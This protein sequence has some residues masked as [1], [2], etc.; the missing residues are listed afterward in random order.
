MIK[1]DQGVRAVEL[2]NEVET[3]AR[4]GYVCVSDCAA[5]S[6]GGPSGEVYALEKDGSFG[7]RLEQLSFVDEQAQRDSGSVLDF[8]GL[9]HGAHSADLSPDGKLLYVADM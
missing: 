5:Y 2:L 1:N 3:A 7:R 6:A 4:S 8:G 9:R